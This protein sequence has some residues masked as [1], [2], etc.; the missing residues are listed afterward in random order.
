M[1]PIFRWR[2]FH[3]YPI[4]PPSRERVHCAGFSLVGTVF[5]ITVLAA[6]AV[7]LITIGTTQRATST[8][9]IQGARAWAAALS[10]KEWAVH[11]VLTT[12]AC[13]AAGPHALSGG[14]LGGFA[15]TVNGCA[16]TAVTEGASSYNVFNITVTATSGSAAT[17]DLVT[18][19]IAASVTDAPAP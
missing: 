13:P 3:P 19:T 5:I 6:L 15:F 17:G 8:L 7:F 1:N 12:T 2:G 16:A 9:S 14:A 11:Q 10:G 4:P 18:R